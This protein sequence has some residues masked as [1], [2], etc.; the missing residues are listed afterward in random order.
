MFPKRCLTRRQSPTLLYEANTA[1][2][3][4]AIH[5]IALGGWLQELHMFTDCHAKMVNFTA[6][7]TCLQSGTRDGFGAYS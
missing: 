2:I 7:K 4:T 1:V 5:R 6:D 3:K